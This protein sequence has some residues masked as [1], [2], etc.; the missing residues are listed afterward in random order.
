VIDHTVKRFGAGT[1]SAKHAV[2]T[3]KPF[4]A[5]AASSKHAVPVAEEHIHAEELCVNVLRIPVHFAPAVRWKNTNMEG[6]KIDKPVLS[7]TSFKDSK[8]SHQWRLSHSVSGA[9]ATN[10][11]VA[12]TGLAT[13]ITK[14]L[15]S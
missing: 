10:L 4:C 7:M 5:N 6:L 1:A 2:Q 14:K 8:M 9:K 13:K 11:Y 12:S 3:S 15:S